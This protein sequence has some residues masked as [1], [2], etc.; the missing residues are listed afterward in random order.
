M[1]YH[2]TPMSSNTKTGPIPV[3]TTSRAS[4]PDS[5][6]FK[7]QGCY[8][9]SGPLALHWRKVT[10]GERGGSLQDLTAAIRRLPRRG[11]WRHNQAGDLPGTGDHIDRSELR[12]I[13]RA[14]KGRRGFT[15]T[16]KP[17]SIRENV[18]AI[19]EANE[20]GFTVNVSAEREDTADQLFASGL[21]VVITVSGSESRRTWQTAGGTTVVAC[22]AQY[23]DEVTCATCQLCANRTRKSVIAF[24]VHGTGK[25][26][27]EK[28]IKAEK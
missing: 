24:P 3:T 22:P 18:A 2:L 8:A 15:Y 4:C 23:R 28:V 12:A 14:N 6:P 9:E 5:C 27:A 20:G 17:T 16:H 7:G 25:K 19:R 26:R 11:L 21:P 13:T 1:N 10:E